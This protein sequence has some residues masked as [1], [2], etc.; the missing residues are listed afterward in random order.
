MTSEQLDDH[1]KGELIPEP[2][3]DADD[4]EIRVGDRIIFRYYHRAFA[5]SGGW[6]ELPGVV[7]R[8]M[9]GFELVY[10]IA[11]CG[12]VFRWPDLFLRQK[13]ILKVLIRS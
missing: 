5:S 12:G 13:D 3:L 9:P 2:T 8:I 7:L 6:T 4:S 10:L 11:V 1:E